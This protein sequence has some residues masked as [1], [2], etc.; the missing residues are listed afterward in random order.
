MNRL[1]L[2]AGA[3]LLLVGGALTVPWPAPGPFGDVIRALV[4][5]MLLLCPLPLPAGISS[6]VPRKRPCVMA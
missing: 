6:V 3:L 1:E 2:K 4:L 5:T